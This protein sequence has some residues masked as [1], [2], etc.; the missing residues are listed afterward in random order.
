MISFGV[1][2]AINDVHLVAHHHNVIEMADVPAFHANTPVAD[3]FADVAFFGGAMDV[4]VTLVAV[5]ILPL[6]PFEPENAGDD[7][8]A[9]RRIDRHNLSGR[10][11][12]L[13]LHA[14][15]G[16]AADF[17]GDLMFAQRCGV[18]AF[19]IAQPEFAGAHGVF[20]Q[21]LHVGRAPTALAVGQLTEHHHFLVRHTDVNSGAG[22]LCGCAPG[23]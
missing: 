11:A 1:E 8:V 20:R 5:P 22:S 17:F 10:P 12:I 14:L 19:L 23:E 18:A 4:N 2:R 3:R 15:W 7:G 21:E 16:V 13:E 6:K 9:P